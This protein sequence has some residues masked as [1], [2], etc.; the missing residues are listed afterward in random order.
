MKKTQFL[1]LLLVC[2]FYSFSQSTE[3]NIDPK[4]DKYY[5]N[6]PRTEKDFTATKIIEVIDLLRW[7]P[8]KHPYK[9]NLQTLKKV[10]LMFPQE[11]LRQIMIDGNYYPRTYKHDDYYNLY[12][13]YYTPIN[14][15]D[16]DYYCPYI[17]FL[18]GLDEIIKI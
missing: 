10:I 7:K 13:L 15:T 2:S 16:F 4:W 3:P 17:I 6:L 1:I 18:M 14:K 5:D 11:G 9:D 12:N 8:T